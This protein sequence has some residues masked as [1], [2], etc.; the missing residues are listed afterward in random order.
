MLTKEEQLALK[1]AEFDLQRSSACA[2]FV[3][4]IESAQKIGKSGSQVAVLKER[5]NEVA[6]ECDKLNSIKWP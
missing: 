3:R 4:L 5:M 6:I 2:A 1:L